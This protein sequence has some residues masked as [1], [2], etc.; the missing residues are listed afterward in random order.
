MPYKAINPGDYDRRITITGVAPGSIPT[1]TALGV[2][3]TTWPT[4]LTA[5]AAFTAKTYTARTLDDQTLM[6]RQGQFRLRMPPTTAIAIGMRV[7]D[8]T[9][10]TLPSTWSIL[11][12]QDISGQQRELLLICQLVTPDGGV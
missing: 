9:T 4:V 6:L 7:V 10:P 8:S 11:D 2:P 5:F 12:V 1:P 3:S